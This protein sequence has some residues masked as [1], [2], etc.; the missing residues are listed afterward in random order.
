MTSVR[1][2]TALLSIALVPSA[3]ADAVG[4]DVDYVDVSLSLSAEEM[5]VGGTLQLH[6]VARNTTRRTLRF[7]TNSCILSVQL[8]RGGF[9]VLQVPA[10]CDDIGLEHVL[11]PDESL[12]A[13]FTFD[14]RSTWGPF[15]NEEGRRV[16]LVLEPGIYE[17][18]AGISSDL[19]S[20]SLPRA[21]R[22]RTN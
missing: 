13:V 2:G 6:V 11:A 7:R 4:P 8:L 10:T 20:P 3:C 15:P 18:R 9:P 22:I 14:G 12:E 17:V 1:V 16:P 5:V 19:L 21:L